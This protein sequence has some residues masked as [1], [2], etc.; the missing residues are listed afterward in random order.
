MRT[1]PSDRGEIFRRRLLSPPEPSLCTDPGGSLRRIPPAREEER[2]LFS[3]GA[4]VG[5]EKEWRK[6]KTF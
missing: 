5:V 4:F 3:D 2:K 6:G 1:S